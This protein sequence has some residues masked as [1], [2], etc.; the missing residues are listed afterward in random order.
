[1]EFPAEVKGQ[2]EPQCIGDPGPGG[3]GVAGLRQP[4]QKNLQKM[5]DKS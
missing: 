5:L 2:S 4:D 1:V 3:H